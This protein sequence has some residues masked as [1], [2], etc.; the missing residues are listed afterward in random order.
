MHEKLMFSTMALWHI[1]KCVAIFQRHP[2]NSFLSQ[3]MD[4]VD[5][6]RNGS[7]I[8]DRN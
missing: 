6:C 8:K 7:E 4:K 1:V 3:L 5:K 2:D